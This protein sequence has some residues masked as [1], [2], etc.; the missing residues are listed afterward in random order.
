MVHSKISFLI[1][2]I[3]SV[4]VFSQSKDWE[5]PSYVEKGKEK[6]HSTFIL[7]DNEKDALS[8]DFSKS[9]DI[10]SLNGIWDFKFFPNYKDAE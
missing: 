3:V 7:F 2:L 4:I 6:P 10:L 5:N 8:Q 9:K 1:L